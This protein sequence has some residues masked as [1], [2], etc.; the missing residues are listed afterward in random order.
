VSRMKLSTL[1]KI[2]PDG[3]LGWMAQGID[4]L[5]FKWVTSLLKF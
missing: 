1:T 3:V 4:F 5:N 2:K